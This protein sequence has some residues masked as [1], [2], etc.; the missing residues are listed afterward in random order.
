[1]DYTPASCLEH[2]R[3]KGD[4][5][6][7]PELER[8]VDILTTIGQ[9]EHRPRT[10]IGF[11]AETQHIEE[12][13]RKKMEKKGL[14]GIVATN[15]DGPDGALGNEHNQVVLIEPNVAQFLESQAKIDIARKI[16]LWIADLDEP[17]S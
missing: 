9:S 10:L 7:Q 12:Y 8:T 16:C 13:A 3:K 5:G 4:E 1:A 14:D 6:W 2:K 17:R 15:V 11:A